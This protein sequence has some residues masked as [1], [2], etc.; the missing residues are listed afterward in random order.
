MAQILSLYTEEISRKEMPAG[1]KKV[2][3][4]ALNLFANKGY[5]ATTTAEIANKA[6]VSEGTIYKYF[7]SK[8]DLLNSLLTPVLTDVRDNFFNKFDL[9]LNLNDLITF[10]VKDRLDFINENIDLFKI[11]IQEVTSDQQNLKYSSSLL[12]GNKGLFKNLKEFQNH[13]PMINSQLTPVQ[14]IRCIIGPIISYVEQQLITNQAVNNYSS[15][16]LNLIKAQILAGLT[17]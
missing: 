2:L 6:G 17:Y 11:L 7:S 16:E 8:R 14:I 1:K 4:A 13:Y 3:V 10:G 15:F 12:S 5:H 9:N